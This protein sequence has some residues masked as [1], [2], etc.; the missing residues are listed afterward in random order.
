MNDS[1]NHDPYASFVRASQAASEVG[2]NPVFGPLARPIQEIDQVD[3]EFLRRRRSKLSKQLELSNMGLDARLT[4]EFI[5]DL[6]EAHF[7]ALCKAKGIILARVPG[8]GHE[9]PDF[10]TETDPTESFEIKT[11]CFLGGER[12]ITD[13]LE[14]SFEG[15]LE[16]QK[17]LDAGHGVG[18]STQVIQPYG[19]I[20]R[21]RQLTR[22]IEIL[23]EKL[24]QNLHHGQFSSSPTYLVC[25]LL[26]LPTYGN[27]AQIIRPAY[28]RRD[29]YNHLQPM[30]GEL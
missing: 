14:E 2:G 23:Q 26:M 8:A 3:D 11:P 7:Y 25:S 10:R 6:G 16:I 21:G 27:T 1:S 15:R 5:Q 28:C 4:R 9:T 19:G 24:R 30:T 13:L 17:R 29:L 20:E 18:F 12:P 22:L